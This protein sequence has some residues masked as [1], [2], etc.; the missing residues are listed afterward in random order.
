MSVQSPMAH[1]E[2]MPLV[3]PRGVMSRQATSCSISVQLVGSR[4]Q[5]EVS[6]LS[7]KTDKQSQEP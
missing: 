6:G 7:P 5:T 3:S 4:K 1:S 2:D